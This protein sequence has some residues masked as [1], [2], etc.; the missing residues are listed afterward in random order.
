MESKITTDHEKIKEWIEER[1][2]VPAM[3]ETTGGGEAGELRIDFPEE[4]GDPRIEEITWEEFFE[5][6]EKENLAFLYQEDK[7]REV[8]KFFKFVSREE[9]GDEESD[10]KNY[11]EEEEEWII[12][13]EEESR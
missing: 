5:K 11:E 8:S 12:E 2:G 3:V 9:Q 10:N 4:E 13:E 1:G 7:S 6:F